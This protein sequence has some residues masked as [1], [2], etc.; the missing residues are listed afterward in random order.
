MLCTLDAAKVDSNTPG[1]PV[2]VWEQQGQA[3]QQGSRRWELRSTAK[4]AERDVTDRKSSPIV[5]EQSDQCRSSTSSQV[6]STLPDKSIVMRQDKRQAGTSSPRGMVRIWI[7]MVH[8]LA[9]A[10]LQHNSGRDH[11]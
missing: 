2:S 11:G 6:Q 4:G 9:R 8:G 3:D 10:W 7:S 1:N 5:P